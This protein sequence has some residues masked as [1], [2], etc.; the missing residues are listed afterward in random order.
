IPPDALDDDLQDARERLQVIQMPLNPE[1]ISRVW[2]TF[3]TPYRL[4]VA[5]EVSVVQLDQGPD[6]QRPLAAR[7][8]T[9]GVPELRAPYIPPRVTGFAPATVPPGGQ[10][11][12]SGDHLAG[13]RATVTISGVEVVAGAV[14]ES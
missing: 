8:R 3:E 12:V 10:L 2:G 5:Y 14:L 6:T 1:E 7:V 11:A 4:S 9:I 13:W